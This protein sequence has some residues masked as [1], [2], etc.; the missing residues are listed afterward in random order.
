MTAR[1]LIGDAIDVLRSFED[2]SVDCV[3]TSPPY[4]HQRAYL[5][6]ETDAVEVGHERSP[7]EYLETLLALMDELWRVLSDDGTYWVNLGDKQAGSGGAGGDYRPGGLKA[8]HGQG[9]HGRCPTGQGWPVAQS[10]CWLPE[11]LGASLAYGANLLTGARHRRWVARRPVVWAKPNPQAGREGRKF[12]SATELLIYG[13]KH[14]RHYFDLDAV[15]EPV[16]ASNER[17]TRHQDGP[18][19][20]RTD[21]PNGGGGPERRTQRNHNPVGKPPLNYWVI[22]T[23][24]YPGAHFAVF[25]PELVVRPVMSGC[26]LGGTVLDPYA[27]TGTVLA[28]AQGH[29]RHAIGIDA[30]ARNGLLARE[31]VGMFLE[32]SEHPSSGNVGVSPVQL[33]APLPHPD[34]ENGSERNTATAIEAGGAQ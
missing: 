19:Q 1:Y 20:R 27:G 18:K 23:A 5:P 32:V 8:D 11:L 12:R 3:I 26:P 10:A 17:N 16:T 7:G 24:P 29:G 15:R 22:P 30:D 21:A 2:G 34:A 13:G 9:L 28:V 6:D 14:Q 4:L 25:P 33:P 31:R